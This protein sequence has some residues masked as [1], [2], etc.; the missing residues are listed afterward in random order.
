M[1]LN[2]GHNLANLGI[3][4]LGHNISGVSIPRIIVNTPPSINATPLVVDAT[5]AAGKVPGSY[6]WVG[7]AVTEV[8]TWYV[9]GNVKTDSYVIVPGDVEIYAVVTFI[10][11][12]YS[13]TDAITI[14]PVTVTNTLPVALGG[15]IKFT[16]PASGPAPALFNTVAGQLTRF[17]DLANWPTT[18]GLITIAVDLTVAALGTTQYLYEMDNGHISLQVVADGRLFLSIKDGAN[19][20]VITSVV[21][22][23]IAA[24]TRYDIIVAVDLAALT[25]WTT[26]NGVTTTR[27]LGANS[28]NLSSAGRKLC[29][30]ARAGGT[31]NNV[32]GA[33]YKLEVWN[34][35]VTG[36]GRPAS[37]TL[38][39]ANGRI[40]PPAAAANAHP[41]KLGGDVT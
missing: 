13:G 19:T 5:L 1:L 34:D 28:G 39:R 38:L 6:S 17:K 36:G 9:D 20:A 37:D 26:I 32:V 7:G 22:G 40:V 2:A 27:T 18:G 12:G 30:L 25:A 3:L 11:T 14:D 10:A 33:I 16:V 31:T 23:T 41:W 15:A 8:W 35:C 21:I 24:N 29:L 4:S